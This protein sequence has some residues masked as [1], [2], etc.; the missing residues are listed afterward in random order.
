MR[1]PQQH[2]GCDLSCR[3]FKPEYEKAAAFLLQHS[4]VHV[5]RLDCAI[6]VSLTV[7]DASLC[8]M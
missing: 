1:G 8:I 3:A 7:A 6:D 4:S 5:Y 2:E